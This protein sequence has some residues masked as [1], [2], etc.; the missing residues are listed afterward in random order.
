LRLGLY[1]WNALVAL[2][3]DA[4]E[5]NHD[6]QRQR[7]AEQCQAERMGDEYGGTAA[8]DDHRSAQVLLEHWA[9]N[10][11]QQQWRRLE[12]ELDQRKPDQAKAGHGIDVEHVVV[13]AVGTD[14]AE[15]DDR[16][17]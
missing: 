15:G 17:E 1:S 2:G 8:A 16:R 4:G 6:Q 13:D 12:V 10:E 5:E 14:T 3:T 11:A 7:N 9:E